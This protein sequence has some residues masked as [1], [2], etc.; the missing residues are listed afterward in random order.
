MKTDEEHSKLEPLSLVVETARITNK[1]ENSTEVQQCTYV[2]K[3]LLK[4]TMCNAPRSL[5]YLHMPSPKCRSPGHASNR[6]NVSEISLGSFVGP[7]GTEITFLG[8]YARPVKRLCSPLP[9]LPYCIIDDKV[10]VSS[11]SVQ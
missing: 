6:R 2:Y 7:P 1:D 11:R 9:T 5:L 4:V 10:L 8:K 3:H